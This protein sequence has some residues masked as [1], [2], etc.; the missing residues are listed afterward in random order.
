MI[1]RT[2]STQAYRKMRLDSLK[3]ADKYPNFEQNTKEITVSYGRV[4]SLRSMGKKLMFVDTR[5]TRLGMKRDLQIVLSANDCTGFKGIKEQ[6]AVGDIFEFKGTMGFTPAGQE[7]LFASEGRLLAP[8]IYPIP[9]E[10]KDRNSI[11]RNAAL[12]FIIN[13]KDVENLRTRSK[14][15]SHI[16]SFLEERDFLGVETPILSSQAGGASA[17]PFVTHIQSLDLQLQLRI[18]PELYL[19]VFEILINSNWSSVAS[20]KFTK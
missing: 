19:K 12:N 2:I 5:G 16:R 6:L 20:I 17:R 10:L 11:L 3:M 13:N 14:V 18:A 1:R 4:T 9:N 7:S 8:C 15:I